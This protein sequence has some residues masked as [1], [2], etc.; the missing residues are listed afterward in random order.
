M[1]V[2]RSLPVDNILEYGYYL[3]FKWQKQLNLL[4]AFQFIFVVYSFYH[5]LG[6][7]LLWFS[8]KDLITLISPL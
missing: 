7:G 4:N 3:Y 8:S 5:P 2:W 1:E 6:E